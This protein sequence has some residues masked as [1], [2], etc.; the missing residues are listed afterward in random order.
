MYYWG[1]YPIEEFIIILHDL[2]VGAQR[3]VFFN[4]T[5]ANDKQ[6]IIMNT[7][8]I[9]G[10]WNIAKGKLKKNGPP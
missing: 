6:N 7:L 3:R 2:L 8:E 1:F 5:T 9:K 4:A 10:D